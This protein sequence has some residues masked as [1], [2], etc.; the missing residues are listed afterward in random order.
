MLETSSFIAIFRLQAMP[1][2]LPSDLQVHKVGILAILCTNIFRE[3]FSFQ[4]T[5]IRND[6]ECHIKEPVRFHTTPLSDTVQRETFKEENFRRFSFAKTESHTKPNWWHQ[7]IHESFLYEFLILHQF[8]RFSPLKASRYMVL[9][10]MARQHKIIQTPLNYVQVTS[11]LHHQINQTFPLLWSY[12]MVACECLHASRT[13]WY[14]YKANQ[15]GMFICI[16][17]SVT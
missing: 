14:K 13:V 15:F 3:A 10:E 4:D 17:V 7:A 6:S 1:K 2:Q 5:L 12:E 9:P 16:M 11:S 8:V